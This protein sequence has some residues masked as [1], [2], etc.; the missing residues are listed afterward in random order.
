MC[1]GPERG[2]AL[3]EAIDGLDSYAP[4][5]VARAELARRAGRHAEAAAAYGRAIELTGNAR[6]RELLERRLA[7]LDRS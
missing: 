7:Q 4:R 6:E 5:E 2:L 1:E 3:I